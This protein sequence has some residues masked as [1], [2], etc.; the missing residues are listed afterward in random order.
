M[1][2]KQSINAVN[3][4]IFITSLVFFFR[5]WSFGVVLWEMATL[6][7]WTVILQFIVVMLYKFEVIDKSEK[8]F[9]WS[10]TLIDRRNDVKMLKTHARPAG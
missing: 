8:H 9:S 10:M 1:G 4:Y 6:G 2:S 7:E 3:L 5:S